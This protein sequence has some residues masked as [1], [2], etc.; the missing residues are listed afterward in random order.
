LEE[1]TD[2]QL[3]IQICHVPS[4]KVGISLKFI[5]ASVFVP[6]LII[7][8]KLMT[9]DFHPASPSSFARAP[10]KSSRNSLGSFVSSDLLLL[11]EMPKE[12]FRRIV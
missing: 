2:D 11:S 7:L 1:K 9:P 4:S 5:P 3:D 6:F 10:Q 12:D 8:R